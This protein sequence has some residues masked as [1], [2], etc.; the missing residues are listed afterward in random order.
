MVDINYIL[1]FIDTNSEIAQALVQEQD[2]EIDAADTRAWRSAQKATQSPL[3]AA[4]AKEFDL[5]RQGVMSYVYFSVL[6]LV[7][8]SYSIGLARRKV[9]FLHRAFDP[10]VFLYIHRCSLSLEP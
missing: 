5:N 9:P 4:L 3:M 1:S 2:P 6:L 8:L 10:F 7:S